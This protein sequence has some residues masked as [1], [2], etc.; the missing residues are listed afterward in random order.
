MTHLYLVLGHIIKSYG[1]VFKELGVVC[2]SLLVL[3]VY[4]EYNAAATVNDE[5][6]STL[7]GTAVLH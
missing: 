2:F 7:I 6:C 5:S 1:N 4:L 3:I